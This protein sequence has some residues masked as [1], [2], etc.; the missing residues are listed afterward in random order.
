MQVSVKVTG[1]DELLKKLD[2]ADTVGIPVRKAMEKSL[3]SIQADA[4]V[5]AK[6]HGGDTGELARSIE[7]RLEPAAIPLDGTVFTRLDRAVPVEYGRRPGRMPPVSA[8]AN[9]LR[10]HGGDVSM[11]FIVARGIA[12]R[13][14][15][16]VFYMKKAADAAPKNIQRFFRD[17]ASEIE[18][19][20][21][22]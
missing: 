6:P 22:A 17:A 7:Y 10:R 15:R 21:A 8:I 1:L 20:W 11:A 4:R 3:I 2:A 13:G 9:F 19:R 14:T 5:G 18:K 12:R 16:G